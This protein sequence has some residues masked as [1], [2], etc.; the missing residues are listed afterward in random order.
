MRELQALLPPERAEKLAVL[1]QARE[2]LGDR[3]VGNAPLPGQTQKLFSDIDWQT[4]EIRRDFHWNDVKDV[5]RGAQGATTPSADKPATP[6][7]NP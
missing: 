3:L 7:D 5:V 6:S 1:T 4:R 2:S